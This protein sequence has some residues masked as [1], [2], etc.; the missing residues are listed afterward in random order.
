M[1]SQI[2]DPNRARVTELSADEQ[3]LLHAHQWV[4]E[5]INSTTEIPLHLYPGSRS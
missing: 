2:A 5:G 3:R 1:N 4:R